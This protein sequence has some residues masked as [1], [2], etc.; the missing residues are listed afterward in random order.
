MKKEIRLNSVKECSVCDGPGVRMVLFFQGCHRHCKGCHNTSTWDPLGGVTYQIDDIVEFIAKYK[1][2]KRITYSG[3]EPL[4]QYDSLLY[5]TK[6]LRQIDESI[7]ILL[8]T[9]YEL[10]DV[11]NELIELLDGIKTGEY[12][13][14]LKTSILDYVGSA[15]QK[16]ISLKGSY[17]YGEPK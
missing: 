17:E 1:G 7:D 10:G 13:E 6:R 9:G 2:K 8:Y 11:P 3:G 4:E 15:N 14:E 5:L 16:L 12:I